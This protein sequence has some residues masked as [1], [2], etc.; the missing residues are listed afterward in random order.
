[1]RC[2]KCGTNNN[3]NNEL[4]KSCNSPLHEEIIDKKE[5]VK[6]VLETI[7]IDEEKNKDEVIVEQETIKKNKKNIFQKLWIS[8][9]LIIL[10]VIIAFIT[11]VVYAYCFYDY[12]KYF[13]DN[14]NRYY[15]TENEQYLDSIKLMFRVYK[16]D[17][18]KISNSQS[19]AYN[20]V[21]NWILEVESKEY[22]LNEE[23]INDLNNLDNIIES[24]YNN[25]NVDGHTAISKKGYS[26][27][28]YIIKSLKE[29]NESDTQGSGSDGIGYDVSMMD[30]VDIKEALNLFDTNETYVMYVGRSTCGACVAYLPALQKAQEEYGYTTKYLDITRIN[31]DSEDFKKFTSLLDI[32]YEMVEQGV[33]KNLPFG[34]WFGYTPMTIIIKD[35]KMVGGEIGTMEYSSLQQLLNKYFKK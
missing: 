22:S 13:E 9:K 32:K 8:L 2:P 16:F 28:K 35:G 12:E 26:S 1:M 14:M 30:E 11:L 15:E 33:K 19:Q 31:M 6:E 20:I 29:E 3:K 27:L 5:E 34:D 23:Y 21:N 24:L 18:K 17:D 4:C 7:K 25:T 10:L